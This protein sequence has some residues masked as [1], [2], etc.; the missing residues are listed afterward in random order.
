M[1][2]LTE[3]IIKN[4]GFIKDKTGILYKDYHTHIIEI[5]NA[6][7]KFYPSIIHRS[8]F[9]NEKDNVVFLHYL[10]NEN[11]LINLIKVVNGNTQY[12]IIQ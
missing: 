2:K 5:I 8:E 6:F 3:E 10:E 11:N 12:N 7:N 9:S 4:Y 1:V